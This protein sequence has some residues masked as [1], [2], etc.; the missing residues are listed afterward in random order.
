MLRLKQ[1]KILSIHVF[2]YFKYLFSLHIRENNIFIYISE[3]CGKEDSKKR[4]N[5]LQETHQYVH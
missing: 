5:T 3:A 1:N 4:Q 2:F